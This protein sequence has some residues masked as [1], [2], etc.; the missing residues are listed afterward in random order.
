MPQQFL[1]LKCSAFFKCSSE[2]PEPIVH[3]SDFTP[4]NVQWTATSN[5]SLFFSFFVFFNGSLSS[6]Y[7]SPT[8]TLGD[9]T[10]FFCSQRADFGRKFVG[11]QFVKGGTWRFAKTFG[12]V[13]TCRPP[14]PCPVET[15]LFCTYT[16][17]ELFQ[18]CSM[19]PS[20]SCLQHAGARALPS[21]HATWLVEDQLN[22]VLGHVWC[23]FMNIC[24]CACYKRGC[25]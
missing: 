17:R 8:H 23:G 12:Q 14:P 4:H 13:S 7:P 24:D 5:S 16:M 19:A 6:I 2:S 22:K 11:Q 21:N 20:A 18:L 25:E 3:S 9:A 10:F 15:T 1:K